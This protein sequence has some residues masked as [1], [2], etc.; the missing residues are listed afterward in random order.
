MKTRIHVPLLYE[1][2]TSWSYGYS[3][4]WAGILISRL[5]NTN[6]EAY[7]QERIFAPLYLKQITFHTDLP[8]TASIKA[9]LVRMKVRAGTSGLPVDNGREVEWSG[10]IPYEDTP[11]G[12]EWGGQGTV[13]SAVDYCEVLKSLLKNDGK[14]LERKSVDVMFTPQLSEEAKATHQAFQDAAP[15][16]FGSCTPGVKLDWG[17]GGKL[18]LDDEATGLR[19][20]TL[21]WGGMP[22]LAWTIDRE[23]GLACFY[24]GNLMPFGD[25]ESKR[26]Q[27]TFER[28]MYRLNKLARES[29]I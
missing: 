13:G 23:E 18:F 10:V 7:M 6:L 11:I 5:T 26:W 16:I 29:K 17:V 9:N 19:K 20:G 28:E 2:G 3:S 12:E 22:N 14:L 27:Q 1:P 25:H 15:D 21:T 8:A 4:D 24:A